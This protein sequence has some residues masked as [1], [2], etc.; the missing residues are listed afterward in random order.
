MVARLVEVGEEFR[1]ADAAARSAVILKYL[2]EDELGDARLIDEQLHQTLQYEGASA[3]WYIYGAGTSSY[4]GGRVHAGYQHVDHVWYRCPAPPLKLVMETLGRVYK[5]EADVQLE[6]GRRDIAGALLKRAALCYRV[7]R[8]RRVLSAC[9]DAELLGGIQIPWHDDP[10]E[11]VVENGILDLRTGNLRAAGFDDWARFSTPGWY[12]PHAKAPRWERF[13]LEVLSGNTEEAAFLQRLF[14]YAVNGTT[15]E[16]LMVLMIGTRG[17]N[18]KSLM[19]TILEAVLGDYAFAATKEIVIARQVS[20]GSP[21]PDLLQLRGRRF[22]WTSETEESAELS[23]AQVKYATGGDTIT[24][25]PL[26]SNDFVSFRPTHTL[27]LATNRAPVATADDDAL[28]ERLVILNFRRR[29]VDDPQSADEAPVDRDLYAALLEEREGILTWLVRGHMEYLRVGLRVPASMALA[30]AEFRSRLSIDD[31]MAARAIVGSM[32]ESTSSVLYADYA[33]W[34]RSCGV[35]E[36][37]S[38]WFGRQLGKLAHRG[39]MAGW[40]G[41]GRVW[42]GLGLRDGF[43][44]DLT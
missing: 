3:S 5:A 41:G 42:R 32:E 43:M 10:M 12:D 33:A 4:R 17:R 29:F 2:E 35:K 44:P 37:T 19:L 28:H 31:W 25:R 18:G 30:K 6:R 36:Q 13:I 11:L 39:I 21:T 7:D 16:H 23:T 9:M 8:A 24:A 1:A 15:R 20:A 40:A 22:V 27:F 14:G 34:C 26:Y 38:A